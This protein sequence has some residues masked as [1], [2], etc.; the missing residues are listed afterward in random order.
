MKSTVNSS[1]PVYSSLVHLS[2]ER[3]LRTKPSAGSR[4]VPPQGS[5]SKG[6]KIDLTSKLVGVV[7]ALRGKLYRKA[8]SHQQTGERKSEN[9]AAK[10]QKLKQKGLKTM[11]SSWVP[12]AVRARGGEGGTAS[13]YCWLQTHGMLAHNCPRPSTPTTALRK[14]NHRASS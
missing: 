3:V 12:T 10:Q 4:E 7:G 6:A 9:Q 5:A 13:P 14:P 8:T 1:I 11:A 2:Q